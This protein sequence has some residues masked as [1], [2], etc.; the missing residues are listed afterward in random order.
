MIILN[1]N[2]SFATNSRC[3]NTD[4]TGESIQI[5]DD[6]SELGKKI[7]SMIPN[8]KLIYTDGKVTDCEYIEPEP[9]HEPQDTETDLMQMSI[10]HEYR[11][12]LLELGITE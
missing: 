4:W 7:I 1:T 11:L 10:D 9:I 3:P 8:V 6:N 5:I 12:T 2:G